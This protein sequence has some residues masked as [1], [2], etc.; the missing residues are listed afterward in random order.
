[1]SY[2]ITDSANTVINTSCEHITNFQQWFLRIPSKTLCVLQS[3]DFVD[4]DQHVNC[5]NDLYAFANQT[6]L[7]KVL[8]EGKLGL[9]KYTRFMRIGIK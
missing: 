5:V 7:D 8:Y 9:E 6:P 2:P 1:M 4:C 3:N